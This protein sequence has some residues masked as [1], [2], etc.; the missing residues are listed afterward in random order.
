ME[1]DL[2]KAVFLCNFGFNTS[3]ILHKLL[4]LCELTH[5]QYVARLPLS[6]KSYY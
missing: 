2:I 3:P 6:F 5:R 4:Y 1:S